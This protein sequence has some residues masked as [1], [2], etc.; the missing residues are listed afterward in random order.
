[1]NLIHST[2]L[3]LAIFS[4][5]A[6][7]SQPDWAEAADSAQQ[8]LTAQFWSST[9][10]YYKHNNDNNPGFDYWW[11][12][13][14][15]DVLVDGYKR[16]KDQ[17]YVTRMHDLLTGM[18]TMNGNK[19]ENNF[20]DDMEWLAI[21]CLR[22]YDATKDTK[23]KDLAQSLWNMIRTGWTNTHGGGIMW[24]K[25]HPA[26]KNACSNG[27]ALIIAA[28]LYKLNHNKEDLKWAWKIYQWQR[29]NLVDPTRGVV[30]D[31]VGNHNENA[32]YTYNQGTWLGG[33]L[34][35]YSITKHTQCLQDAIRTAS[36]V[37]NDRQRFSPNG[38][39]KGE[40]S[41]DGGLFK[42]IFIR[43][44]VQLIR[45]GNVDS[46]T[47]T[48]YGDYLKANGESLLTKAAYRPEYVFGSSWTDLP[49]SS[50]MDC[51]IHL[52]A[53]MLLEA[54]AGLLSS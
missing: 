5:A 25:D 37:V 19:W 23:F 49:A 17:A 10:N 48:L 41:G 39:L 51:S 27:P 21:A 42:G 35:L 33:A 1:M 43:Y 15:L 2:W 45:E 18:Y 3:T 44:L 46:Y 52:S 54:L 38:I 20:Y 40:G 9:G 8:S 30:W 50:K 11:N 47:K 22:A 34:E 14:A 32:I 12:A 7:F 13:H 24:A 53:C 16:T 4:Y 28:R 26:S 6:S 29:S 36:Y 31:G